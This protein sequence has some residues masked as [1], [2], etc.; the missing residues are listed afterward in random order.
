MNISAAMADPLRLHIKREAQEGKWPH[1]LDRDTANWHSWH[2]KGVTGGQE[3]RGKVSKGLSAD[4]RGPADEV[5]QHR[6]IRGGTR[7][8][9]AAV[10]Y[11]A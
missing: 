9:S 11:V 7:H 6:G 2:T 8:Q 4:G 1:S 3:M 10:V 5:R